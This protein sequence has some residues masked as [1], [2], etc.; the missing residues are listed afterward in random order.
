LS[1]LI[2]AA[3]EGFIILCRSEH[4]IQPLANTAAEIEQ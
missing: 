4:S 2:V 1:A 3:I